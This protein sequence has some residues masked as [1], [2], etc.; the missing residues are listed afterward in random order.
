MNTSCSETEIAVVGEPKIIANETNDR[1]DSNP[2]SSSNVQ[3]NKTSEKV[4]ITA[5][6]KVNVTLPIDF[7][8]MTKTKE[9]YAKSIEQ[10]AVRYLLHW[11]QEVPTKMIEQLT[12]DNSY[13]YLD[14]RFVRQYSYCLYS[15]Q[16]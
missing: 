3:V 12:P 2:S 10:N 5:T 13:V 15:R 6:T 8:N 16:I 4:N 14:Q 11:I 1:V 9:R 7:K